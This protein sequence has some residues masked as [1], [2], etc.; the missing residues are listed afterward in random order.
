MQSL[1]DVLPH[2]YVRLTCF[3]QLLRI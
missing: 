3:Q 2:N 1:H